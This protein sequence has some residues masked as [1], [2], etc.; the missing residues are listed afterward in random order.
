MAHRGSSLLRAE[1]MLF[2]FMIA[3]LTNSPNETP[4]L[5]TRITGSLIYDV[6]FGTLWL[7]IRYLQQYIGVY[8]YM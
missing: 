8:A 6:I 4:Y 1:F 2:S 3:V 7:L 5:H